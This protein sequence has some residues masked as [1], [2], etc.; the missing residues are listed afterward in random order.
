MRRLTSFS[1]LLVAFLVLAVQNADAQQS[2]YQIS[3]DFQEQYRSLDTAISSA[4]SVVEIDSLINEVD[5]LEEEFSEHVT[6][7]NAALYPNNFEES[8][9]DLR[10]DARVA[11]HKL[12][13]IENQN[14]RLSSLTNEVSS[15]E[16]EI[17]NLNTRAE[18]LRQAIATS[19]DSERQLS[20]LVERYRSS[21][22]ERDEFILNMIDSLLITYED[23]SPEAVSELSEGAESGEIDEQE[24]PLQIMNT[25]IESN[26]QRLKSADEALDTEDYLRM[27]VV[28]DRFNEVWSQI[29]DELLAIY[30]GSDH[31][32]WKSEISNNLSDYRASA[33]RNMWQSLDVHLE[34]QNVDL[35]AFDNNESFYNALNTF[36]TTATE[37]SRQKMLTSDNYEEFENFHEFWNT[38]IKNDWSQFIQEGE[39]LTMSQISTI[40][41][42]I[43]NWRE[44]AKPRSFLFPILLGVSLL[45]IIGLIIVI[46]RR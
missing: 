38:K 31:A 10:S 30:G 8:I 26:T 21:M 5:A 20:G 34:E 46:A 37:E 17:T 35:D 16:S 24:N 36:V 42:E 40:D 9:E 1:I 22:E 44:E 13:I 18:S 41:N 15:Y 25:I 29:G 32:N 3:R 28:Q 27:Y 12:L 19:E 23:L 39:V 2:D 33:S 11:E 14:E 43:V 7:L 45:I 4:I 6:I